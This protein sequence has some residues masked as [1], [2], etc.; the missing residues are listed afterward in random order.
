MIEVC[1]GTGSKKWK[2]TAMIDCG[3]STNFIDRQYTK[4]QGI[5]LQEMD[6]RRETTAVDGR[7][8][9]GGPTT[10]HANA[11]LEINEHKEDITLH[12]ITIG[13]A[14]VILGRAWLRKHNPVVNWETGKIGFTSPFCSDKCLTSSLYAKTV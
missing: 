7:P 5:P 14:P 3:A 11:T 10:H 2:T 1:L 4:Q 13:G 6:K 9:E 12:N 8:L